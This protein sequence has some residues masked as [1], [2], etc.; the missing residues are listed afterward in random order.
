MKVCGEISVS[1]SL[2]PPQI[3]QELASVILGT[4]SSKPL[5]LHKHKGSK[6]RSTFNDI[7]RVKYDTTKAIVYISVQEDYLQKIKV[8]GKSMDI[9][10]SHNLY[11]CLMLDV[12]II[13]TICVINNI[14]NCNFQRILP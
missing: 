6:Y 4:L 2:C 13:K 10:H 5:S 8:L 3:P 9:L 11:G 14:H 7:Q 12:C 1:V